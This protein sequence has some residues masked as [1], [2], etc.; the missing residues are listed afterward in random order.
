MIKHSEDNTFYFVGIDK[1]RFKR[2]VVPG[3][4][5]IITSKIIRTI[6]GIWKFESRA[7]VN[8]DIVTEAQLMCTMKEL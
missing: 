1:V 6:R 4:C 8:E 5:L 2:P 3:D 7:Q